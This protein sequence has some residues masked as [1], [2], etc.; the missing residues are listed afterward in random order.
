MNDYLIKLTEIFINKHQELLLK[1]YLL[2]FLQK[3]DD[4]C[5]YFEKFYEQ[6]FLDI[7]LQIWTN[8]YGKKI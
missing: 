4:T 5:L 3:Y 8:K 1:D 7:G 6:L 2:K